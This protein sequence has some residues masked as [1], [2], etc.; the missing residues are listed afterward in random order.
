MQ[1]IKITQKIYDCG[2]MAI[3]RVDTLQRAEEIVNGCLKGN[4]NVLEISYTNSNASE[5]IAHIK[6]KYQD[7][8]V[9]GAGTVLDP[10]TA[11]IAILNGAEFI[12]APTFNKDVALLCNRY[13][14]PYAP[15]CSTYSEMVEALEYG[16]AF[17]KVFPVA[18]YFGPDFVKVLKTPLP[19]MPVMASGG[20]TL[21]NAHIWFKNKVDCVGVGTLLTKGSEEEIAK[22][23]LTLTNIMKENR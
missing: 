15:G 10:E 20:V 4:V 5:V 16:S 14:I 9:I 11:R 18:N 8:V 22:N 1:K 12:I 13:Q 3:V 7:Q 2:V 21:E 19:Q 23:A 17:V 6:K